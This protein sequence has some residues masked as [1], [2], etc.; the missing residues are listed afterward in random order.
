[1]P[2]RGVQPR[3]R[4]GPEPPASV[5]RRSGTAQKVMLHQAPAEPKG[6]PAAP[7]AGVGQATPMPA[8]S[9]A[10][11]CVARAYCPPRARPRV[12]FG[13]SRGSSRPVSAP[14]C[15]VE[16]RSH[17]RGP[18]RERQTTP[19]HHGRQRGHPP[20][21]APDQRHTAWAGTRPTHPTPGGLDDLQAALCCMTGE[22]RLRELS[23]GSREPAICRLLP[24]A[25]HEYKASQGDGSQ[26]THHRRGA[27]HPGKGHARERRA[28][29]RR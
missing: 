28:P 7:G 2:L 27:A 19:Q 3:A 9:G 25:R 21:P 22:E 5:S 20:L 11:A 13:S 12:P 6:R 18:R 23:P 17:L 16:R 4:A 24:P 15:V 26:A 29:P 14:S 8:P 10:V 1:M